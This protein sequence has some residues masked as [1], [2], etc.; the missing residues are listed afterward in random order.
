MD[1]SKMIYEEVLLLM[2]NY[3]AAHGKNF[4][5][6]EIDLFHYVSDAIKKQIP[7]KLSIQT[8]IEYPTYNC[9]NCGRFLGFV[10]YGIEPLENE[11]LKHCPNCGQ[12]IQY[13]S[14]KT[15]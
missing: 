3:V 9:P 1:N 2:K 15:E 5:S 6:K 10:M 7:E 13:E 11:D 12:A 8:D 14:E 4:E